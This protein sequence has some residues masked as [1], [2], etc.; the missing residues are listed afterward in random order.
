MNISPDTLVH[1]AIDMH[2]HHGP[3]AHIQRCVDALQAALQAEKA[4]MRAIVLKNHDYP[5]APLAY[6]VSQRV[7][8]LSVF[9]SLSLDFAVGGLNPSAVETSAI[10]GAKVVWMP[11][12]S[13]ANDRER[14]GLSGEGIRIL[15]EKGKILPSV[16]EILNIVK[17]HDMILATGHLSKR[18]AFALVDDAREKGLTKIVITHPLEKRV[19]A[20][21]SIDEQREMAEKGAFIEHCFLATMPLG[22][23]LD[24]MKIIEAVRAVGAEHCLLTTDLGQD[25][26]PPPAQGMRMMVATLLRCGLSVGEIELMIKTNPARLLGLT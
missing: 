9:G 23:R 1:G 8:N 24:P 14:L 16:E 25:W 19:G 10:L 22:D 7:R 11:T 18:E 13:S 26:N 21:L 12:F 20:P 5:T 17:S 3:D 2:V 15:D 4:G 6:I